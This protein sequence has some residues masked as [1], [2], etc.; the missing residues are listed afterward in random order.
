M[1]S[2]ILVAGL[3]GTIAMFVWLSIAHMTMG[4]AG[5]QGLPNESAVASAL[6]TGTGDKGGL[7]IIPYETNMMGDKAAMDRYMERANTNGGAVVFYRPTTANAGM[8]AGMLIEEFIKELVVC[9][10][11]AFLLA[12]AKLPK[13]WE[14]GGIG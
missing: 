4:T 6:H 11:A 2:R 7:Y 3:L 9:V 12:E 14:R 10:I 5:M 1:I 13:V 8:S